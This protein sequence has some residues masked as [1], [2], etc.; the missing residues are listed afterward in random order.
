VRFL[1]AAAIALGMILLSLIAVYVGSRWNVSKEG[2]VQQCEQYNI[3]ALLKA[4][5]IGRD[6]LPNLPIVNL[7]T[8]LDALDA[9]INLFSLLVTTATIVP[10]A[11]LITIGGVIY[12][13]SQ[14]DW[15]TALGSLLGLLAAAIAVLMMFVIWLV[16]LFQPATTAY[17]VLWGLLGI[18]MVAAGAAA[19]AGSVII[20]VI[21]IKPV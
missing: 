11:L 2:L 20:I 7:K 12:G 21:V 5:G 4:A 16:M 6:W 18:P 14:G 19:D 1:K 8:E 13:I 9:L 10:F 15:L 17:Y 3:V